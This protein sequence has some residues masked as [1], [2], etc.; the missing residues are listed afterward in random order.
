MGVP[1][2]LMIHQFT[3]PTEQVKPRHK[4]GYLPITYCCLIVV[5]KTHHVPYLICRKASNSVPN[6]PRDEGSPF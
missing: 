1:S 2:P 3:Q 4:P 5:P 6:V